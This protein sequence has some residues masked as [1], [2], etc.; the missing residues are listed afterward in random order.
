MMSNASLDHLLPRIHAA[1]LNLV[2]LWRCRAQLLDGAL[3]PCGQDIANAMTEA[4]TSLA[5][6]TAIDVSAS[7]LRLVEEHPPAIV[8]SVATDWT[9]ATTARPQLLQ[10]IMYIF[11]VA[12][13][14]QTSPARSLACVLTNRVG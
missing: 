2:A 8:D 4:I 10:D 12:A 6:G 7:S 11:E 3:F 14:L 1:A 9:L 5:W 13:E